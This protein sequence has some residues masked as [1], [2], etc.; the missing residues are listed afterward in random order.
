[1]NPRNAIVHED[2]IE[3]LT[4]TGQ[5][6]KAHEAYQEMFRRKLETDAV[7]VF[8]YS[9]A[10]LEDGTKEMNRQAAW[11]EDKPPF[12]HEVLSEEADAEA[13]AGH[14]DRAR[15]LTNRAVRSALRADNNA[16]AAGWELNSAWREDLFGNPQEAHEQALQALAIAPESREDEAVAALLLARTRDSAR[17][18]ATVKDIGGSSRG[19][20]KDH[21]PAENEHLPEC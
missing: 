16:Q 4:A 11:F 13:Y 19:V 21:K 14:L 5:F 15:E 2:L 8:M 20:A 1:M 3:I 18:S 6:G 7:H 10:A 12:Q 17:A 9:V